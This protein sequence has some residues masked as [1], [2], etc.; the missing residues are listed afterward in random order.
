[1]IMEAET[2]MDVVRDE[3]SSKGVMEIASI[4][5]STHTITVVKQVTL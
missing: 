2:E 4:L 5:T 3:L 1:M